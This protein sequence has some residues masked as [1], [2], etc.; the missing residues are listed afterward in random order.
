[1]PDLD[2]II[3]AKSAAAADL[4]KLPGV[5]GVG[6]GYREKGGQETD[7]Y[8]IRVYVE[9]KRPL[10]EVPA[11]S[12]IPTE[13][14]GFKTDVIEKGH[15]VLLSLEM[16]Q[17]PI[18]GGLQITR[19]KR[20][21]EDHGGSVCCFVNKRTK[22]PNGVMQLSDDVY[23]LSAAHVL[24]PKGGALNDTVYQPKPIEACAAKADI[25]WAN[26]AGLAR[27]GRGV[28]W[29]NEIYRVGPIDPR[30]ADP[31]LRQVV[32]KQGRTTELTTGVVTDI[33]HTYV[34]QD[35]DRR[36]FSDLFMI[37]SSSTGLFG[38]EG[39]SGAPVFTGGQDINSNPPVLVGLLH[40]KG[41]DLIGP[42][43]LAVKIRHVFNFDQPRDDPLVEAN[44]PIHLLWAGRSGRQGEPYV[45]DSS[46]PMSLNYEGPAEIRARDPETIDGDNILGKWTARGESGGP[47]S[48]AVDPALPSD[49]RLSPEG[50]FSG[51]T[52]FRGLE[53]EGNVT[54]TDR[55]G[56]KSAP[57]RWKLNTMY[58]EVMRAELDV[59]AQPPDERGPLSRREGP[60][61]SFQLHAIG[62]TEP[63]TFRSVVLGN[64][65]T[66]NSTGLISGTPHGP[67]API[68]FEAE[69]G[70]TDAQGRKAK[71][72]IRISIRPEPLFRRR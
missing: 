69:D 51:R 5:T 2:A 7:E 12:R 43:A 46:E 60:S 62:G 21:L 1:M 49:L 54:A 19:T 44:G 33:S 71:V 27:L 8:T 28:E 55:A 47:Y 41:Q 30:F 24:E 32:R 42:Y 31:V 26:D 57:V 48:F 63:Y 70:V 10:N 6:V 56:I 38:D 66:L 22:G 68:G 20:N 3:K 34:N 59:F 37:R 65:L 14:G 23:M 9:H 39:D 53:W 13:I 64:G 36:E 58:F 45:L 16:H 11:E 25:N 35:L 15:N 29:K 40:S 52:R 18:V 67:S 72:S 61:Y 50:I 17:R 4:L